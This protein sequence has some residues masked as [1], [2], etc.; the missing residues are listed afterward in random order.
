[1]LTPA[2]E[3]DC[4]KLPIALEIAP[5]FVSPPATGSLIEV[6]WSMSTSMASDDRVGGNVALTHAASSTCPV[7]KSGVACCDAPTPLGA[8]LHA[9]S[10]SADE[11]K[12]MAREEIIFV[13]SIRDAQ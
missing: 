7:E 3:G 11:Q 1:M 13:P 5:H 12:A 8:P 9:A 2:L 6:D 4:T 10:A